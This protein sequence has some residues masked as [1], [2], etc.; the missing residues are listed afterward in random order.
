MGKKNL[1]QLHCC[2]KCQNYWTCETKW[3]RGETN[4]ENICC[5]LCNFYKLCW[6]PI[7]KTSN[8]NVP[9]T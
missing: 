4:Q 6:G 8:K 9:K 7:L 3:H 1:R 2:E 5:D